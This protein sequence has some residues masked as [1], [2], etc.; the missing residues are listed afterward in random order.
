MNRIILGDLWKT[1]QAYILGMGAS[2]V[3]MA[4]MNP[5]LYS[6]DDPVNAITGAYLATETDMALAGIRSAL[7]MERK[8]DSLRKR[9]GILG[10]GWYSPWEGRLCRKEDDRLQVEIPA[11]MFLLFEQVDGH[12]EEAGE[13]QGRYGLTEDQ[14]GKKWVLTDCHTHEKLEYDQ[15]GRLTAM[16]DKNNQRTT[17]YYER[18]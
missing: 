1:I 5:G 17:L 12:Y 2:E 14:L 13:I 10:K 11:D 16:I 18:S 6:V 8:Y 9:S 3:T 4:A 7:L 15:E